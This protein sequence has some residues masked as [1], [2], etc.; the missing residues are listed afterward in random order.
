MKQVA[1]VALICAALSGCALRAPLVTPGQ[2][3]YA[4]MAYV[5]TPDG[6]RAA[7]EAFVVVAILPDG[8][9]LGHNP[10]TPDDLWLL[11]MRAVIQFKQSPEQ[12][13]P[14]VSLDDGVRERV[15]R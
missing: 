12:P 11:N 3:I 13:H 4:I 9:I 10:G 14:P 2:T 1:T 15:S 5:S 7:G 6:I 8:Y